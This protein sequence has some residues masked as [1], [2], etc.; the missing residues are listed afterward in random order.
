M[1]TVRGI[2]GAIRVAHNTKEAIIDGTREL[3]VAMI[4]ENQVDAD[5][6]ASAFFT[7]SPDL[8]A[9]FPAYVTRELGW[10]TV[11]LLCAQEI[12]VPNAMSGMIRILMMV[13]S[14]KS[15]QEIKHQYLGETKSLRPDL[16]AEESHDNRNEA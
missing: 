7:C 15:Q 3:L 4:E 9:E 10:K 8:N 2:R 14:S 12:P 13:N 16:F 1:S 6:I 11:P 5:D